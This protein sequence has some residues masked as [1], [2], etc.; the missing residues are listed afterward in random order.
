[1]SLN[2]FID[3]KQLKIIEQET[4]LYRLENYFIAKN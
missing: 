4:E 1:M 2:D 3:K